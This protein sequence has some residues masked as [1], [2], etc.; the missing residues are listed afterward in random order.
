MEQTNDKE[1]SNSKWVPYEKIERLSEENKIKFL[2]LLDDLIRNQ[3]EQ[4]Q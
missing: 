3:A 1:R 2:D 4:G